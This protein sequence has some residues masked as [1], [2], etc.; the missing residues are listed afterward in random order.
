VITQSQKLLAE[1]VLTLMG[2]PSHEL[3]AHLS[4]DF[5]KDIQ[6]PYLEQKRA[7]RSYR[8]IAASFK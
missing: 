4:C 8:M 5:G 3:K 2:V 7:Y 1:N 6:I